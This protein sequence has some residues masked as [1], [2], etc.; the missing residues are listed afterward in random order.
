MFVF[1]DYFQFHATFY[2]FGIQSLDWPEYSSD[3]NPI[4]HLW[5]VMKHKVVENKP[6]N[7]Q[8]KLKV[9]INYR[10]TKFQRK[11]LKY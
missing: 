7:K 8:T 5:Y 11:S 10:K 6:E 9:S 3:L 2:D 4:D 1:L